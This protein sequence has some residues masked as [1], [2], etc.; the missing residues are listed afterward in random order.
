MLQTDFLRLDA[1]SLHLEQT[2]FLLMQTYKMPTV[3]YGLTCETCDLLRVWEGLGSW[4]TAPMRLRCGSKPY[5]KPIV[6]V[7]ESHDF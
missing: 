2:L 7:G 1:M 6:I 3:I 4:V 5:L